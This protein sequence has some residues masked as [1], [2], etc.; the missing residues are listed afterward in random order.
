[1]VM[2]MV[3]VMVMLLLTL[4]EG[5]ARDTS[6]F[7]REGGNDDRKAVLIYDRLPPNFSSHGNPRIRI[8]EGK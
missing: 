5:W 8:E 2:V 7:I 6:L 4:K 1:M 3:M